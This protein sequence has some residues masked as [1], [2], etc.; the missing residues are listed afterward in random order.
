MNK[1][2]ISLWEKA[3]WFTDSYCT[4]SAIRSDFIN[5]LPDIKYI[6]IRIKYYSNQ[7]GFEFF[8][9]TLDYV[10]PANDSVLSNVFSPRIEMCKCPHPYTGLSCEVGR[11]IL[12][13][14]NNLYFLRFTLLE[15]CCWICEKQGQRMCQTLSRQ[16]SAMWHWQCVPEVYGTSKWT[17]MYGVQNRIHQIARGETGR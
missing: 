2:K 13:R 1:V 12:Q 9:A 15:M 6:L 8:N 10:I 16:L 17:Q 3:N 4:N 11:I 14:D 7:T 5:I